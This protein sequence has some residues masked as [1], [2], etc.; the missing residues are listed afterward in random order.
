MRSV[1]W[2][3]LSAVALAVG[4]VSA[5]QVRGALERERAYEATPVCDAAP[6]RAA[7]CRWEQE[8]TVRS[9]ELNR[10]ERHE[11]PEA[12][13][14]P[15]SGSA[16]HVT[17]PTTEPVLSEA[18]PGERVVGVIWRGRL[19][20]VRDAEGRRQQTADGPVGWPADRLGGA[21]ACLSFGLAGL[22]GVVWPLF[23]RGDRRHA[24]AGQVVRW[25]GAVLGV[26]AILTL[27]ARSA[28]DW[29]LWAIPAI[30]GPLA[31]L[32]VASMTAFVLAA[33]RGELSDPAPAD[34]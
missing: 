12:V 29:P 2:L 18:A 32:G 8:F 26:L 5:V 25:H 34:A 7:Q 17:F 27:W 3:V 11:S 30:W 6:A 10:G 16:W 33:L 20:E 23:R 9:A 28:N 19:V 31:V 24:T 4:V 1:V 21:L 14:V 22:V 15:P 13:L